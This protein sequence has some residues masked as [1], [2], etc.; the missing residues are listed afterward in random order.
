MQDPPAPPCEN[1]PPVADDDALLATCRAG[2]EQAL[3]TLARRH[4]PALLAL[5]VAGRVAGRAGGAP[6]RDSC[7]DADVRRD[8]PAFAAALR[9]SA[10]WRAGIRRLRGGGRASWRGGV[11]RPHRAG[12]ARAG[13]ARSWTPPSCARASCSS[14]LRRRRTTPHA[15]SPP[16]TSGG[17]RDRLRERRA[18]PSRVAS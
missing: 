16:T 5:A 11:R 9:R 2:D 14:P 7:A 12:G 18:T 10:S 6:A 4:H 3:P 1:S 13:R 17:R 15:S 8:A